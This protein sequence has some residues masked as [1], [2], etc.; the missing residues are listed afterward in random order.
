MFYKYLEL[1]KLQTP[2]MRAS[3]SYTVTVTVTVTFDTFQKS[4]CSLKSSYE[5]ISFL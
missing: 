5:S 2:P 4:G 1:R 3:P